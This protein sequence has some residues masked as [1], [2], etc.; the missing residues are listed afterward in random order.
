VDFFRD[1]QPL[2]SPFPQFF[3]QVPADFDGGFVFFDVLD[4]GG[5]T[6]VTIS[7]PN[8][9]ANGWDFLIDDVRVKQIPEPAGLLLFGLGAVGV[10]G[11]RRGRRAKAA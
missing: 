8:A 4:F 6:R 5:I 7:T 1:G 9:A 2:T 10:L 3:P 11:W